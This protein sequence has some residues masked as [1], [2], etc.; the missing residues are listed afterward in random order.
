MTTNSEV[1]METC[2]NRQTHNTKRQTS[3]Q[4]TTEDE[5]NQQGSE[6]EIES[7]IAVVNIKSLSFNSI[8]SNIITNTETSNRWK[9]GQNKYKVDTLSDGNLMP[10]NIFKILFFKVKTRQLAKHKDK[11]H[12]MN[13]QQNKHNSIKSIQHSNN[14]Q[15]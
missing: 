7:H 6:D 5:E 8:G 13:I 2:Q 10:L 3:T 1:Y 15:K 12:I 11:N 14:A 9:R 4:I